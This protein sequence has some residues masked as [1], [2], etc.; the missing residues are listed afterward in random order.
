VIGFGPVVTEDV[1]DNCVVAGNPESSKK[2]C[3]N[4]P[5]SSCCFCGAL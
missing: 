4:N 5:A 3:L 1:P 2:D